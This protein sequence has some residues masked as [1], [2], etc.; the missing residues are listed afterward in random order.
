MTN[1]LI[2]SW[3]LNFIEPNISQGLSDMDT[4][5]E[6]WDTCYELCVDKNNH[7]SIYELKKEI[8]TYTRG[9]S[10]QF[11]ITVLSCSFIGN[12]LNIWEVLLKIVSNT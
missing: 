12:N 7:V 11:Q 8:A 1:D 9:G 5:K 10:N 4:C 6:I 2:S 3:L